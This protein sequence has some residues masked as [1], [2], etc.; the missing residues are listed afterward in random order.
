MLVR[1]GLITK[2]QL[3]RALQEQTQSGNRLGYCLVKLGYVDENELTKLVARQHRMPAV[4]LTR[5]E[6]DPR[7][8]K[9]VPSELATKHLVLPLKRDGRTLTVAMADPSN[10]AVLDDLKFITRYDIFPVL[11]GEYTLRNCDREALRGV[12]RADGGAARGHRRGR[13]RRHRGRSRTVDE[14]D[15]GRGAGGRGR[16]CAGRQ[17]DQRDPDRRREARRLATSTSSA[18]STSCAFATASTARSAK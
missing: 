11:A 18:S 5:F 3:S 12:G 8:I 4:D 16:R 14:D 13:A 9:L 10:I 6:V 17:A 1:E 2:E 15:V 7:I